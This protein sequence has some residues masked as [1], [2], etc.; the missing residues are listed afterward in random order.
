MKFVQA[1]DQIECSKSEVISRRITP[2]AL[3]KIPRIGKC[4]TYNCKRNSSAEIVKELDPKKTRYCE[5][6]HLD[7]GDILSSEDIVVTVENIRKI[8]AVKIG[9]QTATHSSQKMRTKDFTH[10]KITK[11]FMHIINSIENRRKLSK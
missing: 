2:R 6:S 3:K 8:Q 1:G 11:P 10:A 9:G 5:N 7:E 4:W